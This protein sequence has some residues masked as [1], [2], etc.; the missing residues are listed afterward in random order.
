MVAIKL[1]KLTFR[2]IMIL[3]VVL[4]CCN[5]LQPKEDPNQKLSKFA[6]NVV[7]ELVKGFPE[8]KTIAVT[9]WTTFFKDSFLNDIGQCLPRDVAMVSMDLRKK[10]TRAA[11]NPSLIIMIL[12]E[13]HWVILANKIIL[14]KKKYFVIFAAY[15][16]ASCIRLYFTKNF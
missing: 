11:V 3:N 10:H 8:T 9:I 7:D 12:D 6:C 16:K 15:F 13:M 14:R 4:V 5:H 1:V 2:L